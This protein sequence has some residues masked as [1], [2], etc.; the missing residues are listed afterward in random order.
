MAAIA[1]AQAAS[2]DRAGARVTFEAALKAAREMA[3]DG[4]R[5]KA[6]KAVAEAQAEAGEV[7]LLAPI[8]HATIGFKR[9]RAEALAAIG[10]AHAKTGDDAAA[11]SAFAAALAIARGM[12]IKEE[13]DEG[14]RLSALTSVAAA[15]ARAGNFA[16]A[17]RVAEEV[18]VSF[19]RETPFGEIAAAQAHAGELDEALETAR[20]IE[21]GWVKAKALREVAVAQVRAG[22]GSQAVQT[23]EKIIGDR[24]RHLHEI[25]AALA[26]EGD[27]ENFKRL[28]IPC[29]FYPE[30]SYRMCGVLVRLYPEQATAIAQIVQDDRGNAG[31]RHQ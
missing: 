16:A 22:F 5:M 12:E 8:A 27:R 30:A 2:G 11:Q 15:L 29:S 31:G 28:L 10:E 13:R 14:E 24:G 19:V 20:M 21:E 7:G 3:G 23:A 6:L 9:L 1:G 18:T 25:G 4:W 17:F 26:E